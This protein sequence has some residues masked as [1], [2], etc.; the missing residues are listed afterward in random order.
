[1]KGKYRRICTKFTYAVT[2]TSERISLEQQINGKNKPE[3]GKDDKIMITFSEN[4][5]LSMNDI[6]GRLTASEIGAGA[7]SGGSA[8]KKHKD[9][10]IYRGLVSLYPINLCLH[11]WFVSNEDSPHKSQTSAVTRTKRSIRACNDG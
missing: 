9:K 1:M 6:G 8:I 11:L 5:E 4:N 7:M 3:S 10:K 2:K